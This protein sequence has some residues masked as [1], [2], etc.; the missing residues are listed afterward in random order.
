MHIFPITKASGDDMD[1]TV[2]EI[3]GYEVLN[4]RGVVLGRGEDE[5][6]ARNAALLNS[7]LAESNGKTSKKIKLGRKLTNK[8]KAKI[9]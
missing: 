9:S 3:L 6:G 4:D 1:E 2:N 5:E 8:K 7:Y